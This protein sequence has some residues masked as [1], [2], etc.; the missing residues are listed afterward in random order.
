MVEEA[1]AKG[2]GAVVAHWKTPRWKVVGA[3]TRNNSFTQ[4]S[5]VNGISTSRGGTHVEYIAEQIVN[6]TVDRAAKT[7]K[8]LKVTA[9]QVRGHLVLF[10][11]A[12][13]ENPTFDSQ[14]KDTLTL[15]KDKFGSVCDLGKPFL[16]GLA[17]QGLI[18]LVVQY[19]KFRELRAMENKLNKGKRKGMLYV[20]KLEDANLAGGRRS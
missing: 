3:V 13:I 8:K 20:E 10:V 7:A 15:R 12:L 16:K 19:A 18:D 11:N 5:F 4:V 2:V 17:E 14:T 9:G 1:A 6:F